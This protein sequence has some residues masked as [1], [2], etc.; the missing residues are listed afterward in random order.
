MPQIAQPLLLEDPL[1]SLPSPPSQTQDLV[2]DRL[3]VYRELKE[4][5]KWFVTWRRIDWD[6][7][8]SK[9]EK[10]DEADK[11]VPWALAFFQQVFLLQS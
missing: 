9:E 10:E 11:A 7:E 2:E 6:I 8:L 3:K 1:P 4:I 5:Y